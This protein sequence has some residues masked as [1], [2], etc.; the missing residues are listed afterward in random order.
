MSSR[1]YVFKITT[2]KQLELL[3]RWRKSV[4]CPDAIAF[5][6]NTPAAWILSMQ[7]RAIYKLLEKGMFIYYPKQKI[8]RGNSHE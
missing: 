1:E 6:R 3:A 2:L 8:Q 7:G 4:I 5:N